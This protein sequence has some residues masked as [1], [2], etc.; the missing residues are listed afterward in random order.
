MGINSAFRL[1][2]GTGLVAFFVLPAEDRN[3]F[4][5]MQQPHAPL[6]LA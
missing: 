1:C 4:N 3:S 5:P 6:T 2:Q